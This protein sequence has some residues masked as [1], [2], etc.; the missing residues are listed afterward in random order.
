VALRDKYEKAEFSI[1]PRFDHA[2]LVNVDLSNRKFAGLLANDAVLN[3]AHLNGSDL[4]SADLVN[5]SLK[6]T[7]L[8]DSKLDGANLANADMILADLREAS[9]SDAIFDGARLEG[10]NL[11]GV[12]RSAAVALCRA[13]TLHQSLTDEPLRSEI[14]RLCPQKTYAASGARSVEHIVGIPEGVTKCSAD[15]R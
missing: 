13:G 15:Q 12:A 4:T 5:S 3:F 9:L 11:F 1:R 10:V 6:Y 7:R 8:Y 2:L 14:C